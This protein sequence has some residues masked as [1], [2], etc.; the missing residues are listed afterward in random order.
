MF[1]LS[2]WWVA[3][4]RATPHA[5]GDF[6]ETWTAKLQLFPDMAKPT[7]GNPRGSDREATARRE[8]EQNET[9]GGNAISCTPSTI[10]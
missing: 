1:S 3:F 2:C 9:L 5:L 7:D 6:R 4:P 10:K 8:N